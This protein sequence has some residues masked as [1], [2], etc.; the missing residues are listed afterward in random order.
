MIMPH[1]N[2]S[3]IIFALAL[4]ATVIIIFSNLRVWSKVALAL[5]LTAASFGTYRA[6]NSFYGYP[7]MLQEGFHE[8]TVLGHLADRSNAVIYVWLR[9]GTDLPRSYVIPF[10]HD[11][12]R[13]LDKKRKKH[14]GK[15]YKMKIEVE[16]DGTN[17]FG[18]TIEEIAPGNIQGFP[19]KE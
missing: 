12:I 15:P 19:P 10:N 8:V 2:L 11:L 4:V 16:R 7:T 18:Y 5:V 1:F 13:F 6:M 14:R 3:L 9:H 17:P